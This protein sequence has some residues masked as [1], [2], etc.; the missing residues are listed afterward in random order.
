ML[1]A[2]VH[3]GTQLYQHT[4]WTQV[5]AETM[6]PP[7]TPPTAGNIIQHPREMLSQLLRDN[8]YRIMCSPTCQYGKEPAIRTIGATPT[9][10]EQGKTLYSD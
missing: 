8:K 7:T 2:L 9:L 4:H 1:T 6:M 5:V 10:L 3:T